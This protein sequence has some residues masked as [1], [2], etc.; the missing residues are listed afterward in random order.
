M[1]LPPMTLKD[2]AKKLNQD[3]DGVVAKK[4]RGVFVLPPKKKK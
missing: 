1:N 2:W 3:Y 4:M